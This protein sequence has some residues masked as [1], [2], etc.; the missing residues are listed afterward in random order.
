MMFVPGN[1]N[2]Q[3]VPGQMISGLDADVVSWICEQSNQRV[4]EE[5]SADFANNLQQLEEDGTDIMLP[6]E[7]ENQLN[8]I[9][10]SS[11][12]ESSKN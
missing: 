8:D 9:E 6:I 1:I 2:L 7:I 10:L 5:L 11:I 12:P 3:N 4:I